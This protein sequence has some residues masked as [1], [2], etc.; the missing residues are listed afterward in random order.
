MSQFAPDAIAWD[1]ETCPQPISTL[2]ARQERRLK[3]EYANKARRSPDES[4]TELVQKA[5]SFNGFLCWI[6]CISLAWRDEDGEISTVTSSAERPVEERN[7][8]RWFWHN[9][10][11]PDPTWVTFNGKKFDCRITRT[12]SMH[13]EVEITN[14]EILDEYPYSY[15]PHCDVASLWREDWCGLSDVADLY[16]ISFGSKIGGGEVAEAVANGRIDLVE[17]HCEADVKTT[18]RVYEHTRKY[19]PEVR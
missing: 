12:R 17:D 18:L 14:T 4:V 11:T 9:V 7:T 10:K 5:M 8:L 2:T 3:K 6:C 19:N 1:I 15:F 13:K 16:G